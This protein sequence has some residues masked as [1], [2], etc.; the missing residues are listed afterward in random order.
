MGAVHDPAAGADGDVGVDESMRAD[1]DVFSQTGRRVDDGCGMDEG[2][3]FSSL[4]LIV[5]YCLHKPVVFKFFQGLF[6]LPIEKV[7]KGVQD[8]ENQEFLA[9]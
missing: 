8:V 4:F 1:L 5:T 9:R 6:P 3:G 7:D 2:H